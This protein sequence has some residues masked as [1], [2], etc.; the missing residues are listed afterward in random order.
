[1]K[2]YFSSFHSSLRISFEHDEI[3]Q[4]VKG[5]QFGSSAAYR[6]MES[7]SAIIIPR[8]ALARSGDAC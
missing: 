1:L 2:G 5:L 7:P 6:K 3:L 4:P 8:F